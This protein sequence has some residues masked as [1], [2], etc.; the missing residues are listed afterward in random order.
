MLVTCTNGE[1]G[2]L[3]GGRTRPTTTTTTPTRSSR[4][5]CAELEASCAILGVSRL[6]LLGYHDSGMMGW[7]QNEAPGAF[8]NTPVDRGGRSA[9]PSSSTRSGPRS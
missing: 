3:G 2:E 4:I 9:W 8:W 6:V 5:A 7:P 1:Y